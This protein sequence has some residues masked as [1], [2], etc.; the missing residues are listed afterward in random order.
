MLSNS[1]KTIICGFSFFCIW[2]FGT[3]ALYSKYSLYVDVL[4]NIKWSHHLSI[5]YDK[6]PI[7]G[8]LLMKVILYI[9][10]NP[11]LAGLICSCICMLTAILF[12]YKLL[13]LYFNQNTTLFLIILALL[14]SVFGDY[15]F[16]QFN[17][18]VI[19]LPFWIMT[20]Y[21]FIL[22]SKYNLLKDWSL[23]A[24]VAALGMYSK[25][26]I[27]LLILII[28]FFL[29]VNINKKNF[30]KLLISLSIFVILAIP[31]L[32]SLFYSHFAPIRYAIGEV[33]SSATNYITIILNLF[34]AQLFNLSSLGY[35]AIPLAFIIFLVLRK[36]IY[37]DRNKPFL[38]KLTN[39]LVVCGIYPLVFF[40]ILQT[41][42]T[43]LEYGWLMCIMSLTLP[44]LFYLFEVNIKDKVFNNIILVFILIEIVVF[45][46]YNAF[47]YF[48][49][50]L[51]TRNFGNKIA[52]KAEQ[53]VKNNLNHDINYVIGDSPNYN[54]M[55][56]SV[57]ALL[58][59]KPY[60]FLKFNDHNIP[61]NQEI[62][63]VFA[64]CDEQKNTA[65]LK[66]NSF[67]IQA[68]Q[69]TTIKTIDKFRN[70][71]IKLSF[72]LVEKQQN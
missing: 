70:T 17:Q 67:N 41:Y 29:L 63:A 27:G 9:T 45:I 69:C 61:Y 48:S 14:S 21:Y 15:S 8:S 50:Q 7:M 28:F 1:K 6:H 13:K 46:T 44:A 71:D 3:L 49:P 37:F 64:D 59:S 11:M 53:F 4:E 5:V 58:K 20:C 57:G 66:Q 47:T 2:I 68:Y 65:I 34:Y 18:N 42:A 39:P 38:E 55:S 22:V 54:Q 35:I 26:E 19:L 10:S 24:I 30:A 51:T 31:L 72:Y 56:L 16:V 62:L 32:S 23:L 40:F 25:F 36:K 60:V 43:H 52:V 12:L 33:N